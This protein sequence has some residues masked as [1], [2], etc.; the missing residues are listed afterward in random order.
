[1]LYIFLLLLIF[2]PMQCSNGY[3]NNSENNNIIE[4][5]SIDSIV[6][7]NKPI[8]NGD[9]INYVDAIDE[10]NII[11]V[12]DTVNN[13]NENYYDQFYKDHTPHIDIARS[14]IGIPPKDS[15]MAWNKFVNI[16][17]NDPWCAASLSVWLYQAGVKSP[18]IRSG[19][20]RHFITRGPKDQIISAGRVLAGVEVVPEG[21]LVVL[22]RGN[23]IF[24]HIG[25]AVEPWT[26]S[27]GWYI[28]GNTS[29]PGSGGEEHTG[30]GVWEKP[31]SINPNAHLR[32]TDFVLVRY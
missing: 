15:I 28:S 29:A 8:N 26:G 7:I 2:L 16:G 14:N 30:G 13:I 5:K 18:Q 6:D 25:I 4:I 1:M 9:T 27:M 3:S 11:N 10:K 31:L 17:R 23:T 12:N 32:V 19:L 20:A 21:S 24:G 22:R